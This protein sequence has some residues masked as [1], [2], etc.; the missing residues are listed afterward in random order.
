M[1]LVYVF[2]GGGLGSI[3]RYLISISIISSYPFS[4]L[5]SNAL[6]SFLLGAIYTLYHKESQH[7]MAYLL[8]AAGFCGGFSTFSTF[9]LET[10]KLLSEEQFLTAI[11]NVLLNVCLC[12]FAIYVG[13]QIAQTK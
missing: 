2:I 3:V 11:S 4:T 12:L 8:L 5:I 13:I 10:F 7:P 6:S 9:S 1:K